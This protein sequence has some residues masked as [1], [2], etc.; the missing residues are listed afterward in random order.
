[1]SEVNV[2][3]NAKVNI[4][5]SSLDSEFKKVESAYNSLINKLNNNSLDKPLKS[6]RDEVYKLEDKF[7]DFI[8]SNKGL[9]SST[10]DSYNKKIELLG[11]QLLSA[12][13]NWSKT[14][15][16]NQHMK[17][18]DELS[19]GAQAGKSTTEA[20]KELNVEAYR[21]MQT[22]KIP[23]V[24]SLSQV[25]ALGVKEAR[26]ELSNIKSDLESTKTKFDNLFSSGNF[27]GIRS[28]TSELATL[29]NRLDEL[30]SKVTSESF[31]SGR[32][33]KTSII[34]E[35][36]STQNQINKL[37]NS[38]SEKLRDSLK[39]GFKSFGS[40]AEKTVKQIYNT[41]SK[42]IKSSSSLLLK[43]FSSALN[44][45]GN[46]FTNI[47]KQS[48]TKGVGSIIKTLLASAGLAKIVKESINYGSSLVEVQN[49]V[50]NVFE[51]MS[52]QIEEF[53]KT[54]SNLFGLTELQAKN[55]AGTF[56]G[57][58]KSVGISGQYITDMSEN[59]AKLSGDLASFYNVDA[60][61]FFKKIQS[62]ITGNVAALRTY[63]IVVSEANLEQFRLDQG[64]KQSYKDMS[65]A[66]KTILR[67]NYILSQ[68]ATAQGDFAR[69]SYTWANQIRQLSNNFKQLG[70]IIGGAF[71]K[72]LLP[73][74]R[75][76][77]TIVVAA[78]NA[79][80]SLA[81]LFGFDVSSLLESAGGAQGVS[82]DDTALGVDNL[83][84]SLSDEANALDDTGKA[85]K[86]AADNLQGFDKLNNIATSSA[87]S[88]SSGLSGGAG[89]GGAL[90]DLLDY[91]D[92]AEVSY[93]ET[94]LE[95]WLNGL[96]D[97]ISDKKW[98]DSG[99]YIASGLNSLTSK[100]YNI[101]TNKKTYD[102]ISNFNDSI[103]D[104]YDGLL[105]YDTEELGKTFGA[106]INLIS[107]SINDLYEEAVKKDLLTKTGKKIA[108]FFS[109]LD[110]EVD[111][112]ALGQAITTGFRSAMDVLSGFLEE[113]EENDLAA[114]LGE[115]IKKFLLGAID[116]L[117]GNGVAKE[118]GENIAGVINFALSFVS[119]VLGDGEVI[120][121]LSSNIVTVINTAIENINEEDLKNAVTSILNLFGSLFSA[122]GDIDTDTLSDKV[123]YAVNGAVDSGAV[124]NLVSGFTSAIL[125]M[126][127][128]LGKI[129]EKVDKT[130]LAKAIWSG[131]S[132]ALQTTDGESYFVEALTLLFGIKLVGS[133]GKFGLNLLGSAIIKNL[134]LSL[135]S[136]SSASVIS[137]SMSS[138]LGGAVTT[139]AV[140]AAGVA[141][142]AMYVDGISKEIK[143]KELNEGTIDSLKGKMIF[144]LEPSDY[145]GLSDYSSK[146]GEL[147]DLYK[148]FGTMLSGGEAVKYL[149][150][151]S[152]AGAEGSAEF[153]NLNDA[154]TDWN[155]SSILDKSSAF[156]AVRTAVEAANT[157]VVTTKTSIDDLNSIDFSIL[158]SNFSKV[159]QGMEI[160]DEDI[161]SIAG[162]YYDAGKNVAKNFVN[163]SSETISLDTTVSDTTR[164]FLDDIVEDN[165]DNA[166]SAGKELTLD[167]LS[168]M[169]TSLDN[170]TTVSS[171]VKQ[172]VNRSTSDE[173]TNATNRGS[174]VGSNVISGVNSK[175][176]T[177]T[178]ISSSLKSLISTASSDNNTN[179]KSKGK[180][181]GSS[182]TSGA[183]DK[184]TNDT[185]I[186]SSLKNLVSTASSNSNTDASNKGKD[187]GGNIV[188]GISVG[189]NDESKKS[190]LGSSVGSI[191]NWLTS[192]FK[193]LLDIHSPSRVF[194]KLSSFIPEGVAVGI[195]D[196]SK[197]AIKALGNMCSSLSDDFENY[198]LDYL[199]L[200]SNGKFDYMYDSL[201]KQTDYAFDYVANKFES[202]RD[203]ISLQSSLVVSPISGLNEL[204]AISA[205]RAEN[206]GV[207]GA[208]SNVYS[209][210]ASQN[211]GSS[212]PIKIDVYLDQNNKLSSYIINTVNGN[213]TKTGGF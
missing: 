179:A 16:M 201:I 212:R 170:D 85:A 25:N 207:V 127:N 163:G 33:S 134:G 186:S 13:N 62:G 53:T 90:L 106:A 105:D 104:L 147:S 148:S 32:G 188:D 63:G 21:A 159:K 27:T 152:D 141:V 84:D 81:K 89:A 79:A 56:G 132:D 29:K 144:S 151:L 12:Q 116:R 211:V 59:L 175:L 24:D 58:L 31:S 113:A 129:I 46:K 36:D 54:S 184:I 123:S 174:F 209:K 117:F 180:S 160:T 71:I 200:T 38:V 157:S 57:I 5:T 75:V 195:K 124:S 11:Q 171:S 35:I 131:I 177:D 22:K 154:L 98:K 101:L 162:G 66:N 47:F 49:I 9:D 70:A 44:A 55:F 118:I 45:I 146:L 130:D 26:T 199:S 41:S 138:L 115:D 121:E 155:N 82:F 99:K 77:N 208:L 14:A 87:S 183:K 193:S 203:L 153:K 142:G 102:A 103:T 18:I 23:L 69:T 19:K 2:D 185:E 20:L 112:F 192:K 158:N 189:L 91:R 93:E 196:N 164:V 111:W 83:T 182:L 17:F 194:S 176:S 114:K 65:Q 172:V 30:K 150:A 48:Q 1:M 169:Y 119:G 100:L 28:A 198:N 125:N 205:Q 187:I 167:E 96:L 136:A 73:V 78:I 34:N 206:Q 51:D 95:K 126:F 42:F 133:V 202:L 40:F 110:T 135:T 122:I 7:Q 15:G 181:I 86:D 10:I 61:V 213:V 4:D 39:N 149:K 64:I 67:Y 197:V 120:D 97:L 166:K 74:V 109:G 92:I 3:I 80:S 140:S 50:D 6:A 68:T 94:P 178:E 143:S 8:Y 107:F 190:K 108:K 43:S 37:S 76:L 52:G 139:A 88:A 145:S 161:Q 168:G 156:D 137:S 165:S 204:K 191:V 210:L 173:N 60:D 128:L 72:M